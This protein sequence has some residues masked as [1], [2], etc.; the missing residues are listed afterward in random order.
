MN[1]L[2]EHLGIVEMVKQAVAYHSAGRA[3][4]KIGAG[5]HCLPKANGLMPMG[6]GLSPGFGDLQHRGSPV[7]TE[8]QAVWVTI[9]QEEG[10]VAWSAA[11]IDDVI[12]EISAELVSD[13]IEQRLIA[14]GKIRLRIGLGLQGRVHQFRLA[15]PLHLPSSSKSVVGTLALQQAGAAA[16]RTPST[17]K[18]A[19][20]PVRGA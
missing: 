6:L 20:S 12:T 7:D 17:H 1:G 2:P 5:Q 18:K 3:S 15:D 10:D 14:A 13:A 19:P 16:V 11:E 9:G 8:H 4:L